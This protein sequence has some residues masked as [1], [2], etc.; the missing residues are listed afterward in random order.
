M[1]TA[2]R[3][4]QVARPITKQVAK[5]GLLSAGLALTL[6]ASVN[7]DVGANSYVNKSAS[8]KSHASNASHA[9]EVVATF[10][11]D[12]P[13]GN[14]AVGPDGRIFLSVHEFY[15]QPLRV[16]ELLKDGTTRPYPN[17]QWAFAAQQ[18]AGGL[19]GV[20]G[21]NV[22]KK[23]ILWLLDTSGS[24]RA[25]RLVGWDTRSEQLHRVIY[26]AKPII[27]DQSFLND[28][29]IDAKHNAIY[30]ADTGTGAIIVVDLNTGQARTVLTKAQQTKA[31]N[32]DMVI[33]GNVIKL[34]GQTARLGVNPITISHDNQYL[35]FGAMTGTSVY[36]IATQH[37]LNTTLSEQALVA[38]VE[39]YGDKPISDGITIDNAGNIYVT[40]ITNDA[41]GITQPNGKYNVLIKQN[42]LSWPDGLAV[43][44][45]NYI[46]ATINE[47]HRSP[48]LNEGK[49][50]AKGE[51]KVIRFKALSKASVGR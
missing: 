8:S 13:P 32:I 23:G 15:N 29:A 46:Y 35:Y 20:L 3:L 7:A 24:E 44:P 4:K 21:I 43:G 2:S 18:Q 49:N 45:D 38:S 16:V 11:A 34:G 40:S 19:Y 27:S 39:R 22:D 9:F 36:R 42:N 5:I 48:I 30:I 31:E 12:T 25:G 10:N 28:F 14:I 37:L 26:L 6:S 1:N 33:D 47:L 51:F 17:K 41:I 50:D